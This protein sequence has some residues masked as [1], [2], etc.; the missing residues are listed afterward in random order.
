M[1]GVFG[2]QW[3][4]LAR[5]SA[6]ACVR[7]DAATLQLKA[8]RLEHSLASFGA[9]EARRIAE[10]LQQLA[11]QD[12]FQPIEHQLARLTVEIERLIGELKTF[13]KQGS[14]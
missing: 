8:D 6:Q 3:R 10:Q 9:K 2:M 5:E 13:A 4:D 7:R 14:E 11:G 12:D 1:A